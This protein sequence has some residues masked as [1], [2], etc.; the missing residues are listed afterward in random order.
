MRK[1]SSNK[2]LISIIIFFILLIIGGGTTAFWYITKTQNE[3]NPANISKKQ[4]QNNKN[5]SLLK[6]G[7]LYP[8]KPIS[9]NVKNSDQKD[10][11]LKITL[12]LELSSKI[13]SYELN[14]QNALIRDK[15]ITIL[16]SKT[17]IDFDSEFEKDKICNEI[18]AALNA[19]LTDG[20]IKNA[21]I[22]SLVIQSKE[23]IKI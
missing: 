17:P 18:K 11:Y 12:T 10:H 6:I 19:I 20:Q 4:T 8:L 21:Y 5:E 16:K 15:I 7:P 22:V 2:F 13:L 1:N 3:A 23:N 14:T 9:V